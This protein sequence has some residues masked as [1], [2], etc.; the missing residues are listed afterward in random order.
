MSTVNTPAKNE[1]V[2][3][4]GRRGFEY[5]NLLEVVCKSVDHVS[6]LVLQLDLREDDRTLRRHRHSRRLH[7]HRHTVTWSQGSVATQLRCG[8]IS[9]NRVISN[10]PQKYVSKRNL[11]ISQ[12]RIRRRYLAHTT[13]F[14]LRLKNILSYQAIPLYLSV[15]SP[16]GRPLSRALGTMCRLSV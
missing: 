5:V 13:D 4:T 1:L 2:T 15:L 9:D 7:R 3:H 14:G 11:Q 6:V 16:F 12:Y 8:G 10:S